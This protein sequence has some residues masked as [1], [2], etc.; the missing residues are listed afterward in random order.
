MSRPWNADPARLDAR[1]W[2]NWHPEGECWVWTGTTTLQGYGQIKRNGRKLYAHRRAYE[3]TVGPIPDGL[4][5]MHTC[6]NPPCIR[7]AHLRLGTPGDNIRDAARKGRLHIQTHPEVRGRANRRLTPD[8]VREIRSAHA[9][10]EASHAIAQ[11][12][13]LNTSTVWYA[14]T[15]RTFSDVA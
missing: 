3:M 1:F 2:D 13:G 4:V 8:L 7:P 5:V 6:D 10:G 12:L 9:K 15:G 14:A 11:R